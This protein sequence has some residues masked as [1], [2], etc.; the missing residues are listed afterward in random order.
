VGYIVFVD[1]IVMI[2]ISINDYPSK[3]ENN[4]VTIDIIIQTDNAVENYLL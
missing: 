3:K 1:D 2:I 4:L